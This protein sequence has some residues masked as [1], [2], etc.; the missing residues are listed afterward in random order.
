[1]SMLAQTLQA[2]FTDRLARQRQA[3][4]RTVAA[5]RDTFRLLL[6][7]VQ[8]QIGKAPFA[9]GFEHL[10]ATVIVAFLNH[11]EADRHNSAGTRNARLAAIRSFFPCAA[12]RQPEHAAVIQQV[13]AIPQK[14]LRQSHR[15]VPDPD[16]TRRPRRR[17]GPHQ[18]G[19]SA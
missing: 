16:R 14:A 19:R 4:P 1:M 18:L 8:R 3:S 17:S 15:V 5:Y 12:L 7:F 2:F 9:L 10:E 11:I 13:L 6:A